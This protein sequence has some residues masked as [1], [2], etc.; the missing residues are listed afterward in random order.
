[1]EERTYMPRLPTGSITL[2]FTDIEGSTR[3]RQQP[4][5]RYAAVFRDCRRLLRTAFQQRDGFEVDTQGDSFFV[6]FERASDAV[7]AAVNAQR[8]LFSAQWP[9]G[10][11]VRVRMGL[12]TGEPQP[13]EEGYI[14]LDVHCAARI[15]SVAHGGQ[16]LLSRTTC[17]LVTADFPPLSAS[18][19]KRPLQSLPSPATSFIGR[20]AEVAAVSDL[21]RQTDI[22][23]VT[24]MGT[25]GVGKTRLTLQVAAAFA[26][27]WKP[28]CSCRTFAQCRDCP[29]CPARASGS[30]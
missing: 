17:D 5:K 1:M 3:L 27:P 19:S 2:L 18:S 21:L 7:L 15:M 4:G 28:A 16:V 26:Q 12:H 29:L 24:L 30:T 11:V 9:V 20:E 23:M 6:V 8:A 22:R 14:G 10:A 13:T 25:A